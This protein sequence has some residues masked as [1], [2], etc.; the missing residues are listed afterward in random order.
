MVI[1]FE[2]LSKALDAFNANR[3]EAE[4]ME[5]YELIKDIENPLDEKEVM[6]IIISLYEDAF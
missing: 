3:I 2:S 6:E 5:W 1:M 4:Q